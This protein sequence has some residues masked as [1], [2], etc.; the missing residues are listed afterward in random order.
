MRVEVDEQMVKEVARLE[1][2]VERLQKGRERDYPTRDIHAWG[3][4]GD[5]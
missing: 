4:D 2:E 3:E 1:R 5:E